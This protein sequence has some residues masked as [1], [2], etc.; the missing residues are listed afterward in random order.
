MVKRSIHPKL[1]EPSC[2]NCPSHLRYEGNFAIKKSGLTMRPGER[3]CVFGKKARRFQKRDPVT[4]VPSWCPKRL[5]TRK[6]R[7]YGFKDAGDW[8]LH[9]RLCRDLGK[10]ISPEGH[11][12]AVEREL[13]T[14]LTAKEFLERSVSEPDAALLDGVTLTRYQ[15]LEIDDGLLPAYFYKTEHG[16]V[17]EPFFNAKAAVP[18]TTRKKEM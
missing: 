18:L 10:N 4:R 8:L 17:Y 14:E 1:R 11:H 3:F 15:V 5:K 6:A 13:D 16:Y 2:H 7:I 12:Y 9:E